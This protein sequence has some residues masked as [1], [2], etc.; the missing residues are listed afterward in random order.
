MKLTITA[1]G[2]AVILTAWICAVFAKR[3]PYGEA[4]RACPGQDSAGSARPGDYRV[5][6]SGGHRP[7]AGRGPGVPQGGPVELATTAIADGRGHPLDA[8]GTRSGTGASTVGGR[9][10]G[11]LAFGNWPTGCHGPPL[12]R[13]WLGAALRGYPARQLWQGPDKAVPH[14]RG[15]A[16][17]RSKLDRGQVHSPVRPGQGRGGLHS[18]RR[19]W[20]R[21]QW[22]PLGRGNRCA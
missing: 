1:V 8:R 2:L 7:R 9:W 22:L 3:S 4:G 21:Q 6:P 10:Q 13:G 18:P 12:R 17:P 16:R 19:V 11:A 5:A 15:A 20:P 14:R